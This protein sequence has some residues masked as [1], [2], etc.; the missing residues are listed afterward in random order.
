MGEYVL[1]CVGPLPLSTGFVSSGSLLVYV[2]VYTD[3]LGEELGSFMRVQHS[4]VSG[5]H[6]IIHS[7]LLETTEWNR[8]STVEEGRKESNW[9]QGLQSRVLEGNWLP[10]IR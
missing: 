1:F 4:C 7:L 10:A 9:R 5:T 3:L 8:H 2:T 6:R